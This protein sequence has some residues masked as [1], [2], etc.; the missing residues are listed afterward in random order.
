MQHI[1]FCIISSDN[2]THYMYFYPYL[3]TR[4]LLRQSWNRFRDRFIPSSGQNTNGHGAHQ[5]QMSEFNTTRKHS[6]TCFTQVA[7]G[8]NGKDEE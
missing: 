7:N 6:E 1:R 3:Q 5:Y 8:P 2:T 4:N